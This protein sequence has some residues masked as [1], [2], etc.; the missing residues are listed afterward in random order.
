[1]AAGTLTASESALRCKVLSDPSQLEAL[2][3]N[4]LDLL[5]RSACSEAMQ[6]PMW[7]IPWWLVFGPQ[8]GRQLKIGLF[9]EAER[10]VGLA[11]LLARRQWYRPGLPFRRL[12]PLGTGERPGER[13]WSDYVGLVCERG[14]ERRVIAAFAGAL[15]LGTFGPWDELVFPAMSGEDGLPG[16]LAEAFR[17]AGFW[18]QSV[19]TSV[20]PYV[21]LPPTWDAYLQSLSSSH[22]YLI[23]RSLRDFEKWAEGD[24][25]VITAKTAEELEEGRRHLITLHTERWQAAG[26]QGVFQSPRFN[27]F[28]EAAQRELLDAGALDLLWLRARGEV[29]AVLYNMRWNGKISMYQAGRQLNLPPTIRPGVVLH[30]YAIQRAIAAGLREYDFLA[31][32]SR[33]KSQFAPTVRPLVE[34][35]AT[36][37]SLRE[38]ARQLVE[39]AANAARAVR[40]L[41]RSKA[42]KMDAG[43]PPAD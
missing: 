40:N 34:V 20:S 2:R 4:W 41:R 19:P 9:Y 30:A 22:R 13:V 21:A 10:L 43:H 7:L 1:M 3:P 23:R 6:T 18:A 36:Q 24:F 8:D 5:E 27:A 28:H 31:G 25:Q 38:K 42:A 12:E 14:G 15:K 35:R 26:D 16:L 17:S 33:Y 11:P 29:I 32:V 39:L 37:R